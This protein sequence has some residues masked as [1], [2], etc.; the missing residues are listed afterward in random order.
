MFSPSASS[1]YSRAM[2]AMRTQK[3]PASWNR[4]GSTS[5]ATAASRKITSLFFMVVSPLSSGAVGHALAKQTLR[6]QR[7]HQDQHDEGED[8]L[9]VRAEHAAGE[10]ADVAGAQ[11]LDQ[12]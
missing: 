5:S 6:T 3:L 8:V 10:V 7:Q 1:T 4:I 12:T 9:V 11:R 2:S